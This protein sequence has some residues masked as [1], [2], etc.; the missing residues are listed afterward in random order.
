MKHYVS[1]FSV[2]RQGKVTKFK[3]VTFDSS[4][5]EVKAD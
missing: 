1:H 2:D 5:F 4:Q 3:D